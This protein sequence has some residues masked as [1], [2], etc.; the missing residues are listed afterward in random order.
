M[1]VEVPSVPK[2]CSYSSKPIRA[3]DTAGKIS[4]SFVF[5]FIPPDQIAVG[6]P[7]V[8]VGVLV[9]LALVFLLFPSIIY[10]VRKPSWKGDDPDFAPF[11]W[12][13]SAADPSKGK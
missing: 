1:F 8:Y 6:S 12:E 9:V 10:A 2:A 11:T 3:G 4:T 5:S 13:A 7:E